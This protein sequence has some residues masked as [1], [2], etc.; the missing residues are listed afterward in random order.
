[1]LGFLPLWLRGLAAV[2]LGSLPGQLVM[3]GP[4]G[5]PRAARA[6]PGPPHPPQPQ[7]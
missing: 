2:S 5:L 3:A 1:M 7:L 6:L 4:A